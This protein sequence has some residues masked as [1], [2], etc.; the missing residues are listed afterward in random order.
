MVDYITTA[1]LF[2]GSST[3]D[4]RDSLSSLRG[5]TLL[6]GDVVYIPACALVVEKAIKSQNLGIRALSTFMH[7]ACLQLFREYVSS[8]S[9]KLACVERFSL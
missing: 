9:G 4:D 3:T 6:P 5:G 1:D 7:P 2:S 8:N